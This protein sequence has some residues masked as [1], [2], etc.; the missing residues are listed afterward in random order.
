MSLASMQSRAKTTSNGNDQ[1]LRALGANRPHSSNAQLS[2]YLRHDRKKIIL[3]TVVVSHGRWKAKIA[4]LSFD[5]T[6]P[7]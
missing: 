7:Q 2:P 3:N 1:Y 6:S 5:L 4:H